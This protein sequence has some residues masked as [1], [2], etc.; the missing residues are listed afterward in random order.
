MDLEKNS[1]EYNLIKNIDDIKRNLIYY[2]NRCKDLENELKI[3][4]EMY[5]NRV[6]EYIELKNKY[7]L[8]K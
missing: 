3:T 5:E 7:N 4:K 8:K 1:F 2:M 6:N